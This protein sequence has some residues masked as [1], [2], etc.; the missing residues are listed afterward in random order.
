MQSVI[1]DEATGA[2]LSDDGLM[3]GARIITTGRALTASTSAPRS[4]RAAQ[5]FP[6][7]TVT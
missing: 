6:G 1:R 5:P 4:P 7:R 2:V 3:V